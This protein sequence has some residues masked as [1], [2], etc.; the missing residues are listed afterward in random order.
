MVHGGNHMPV[1]GVHVEGLLWNL[2]KMLV[3]WWS[4]ELLLVLSD[5]LNLLGQSLDNT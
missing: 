5:L 4:I 1:L 3:S 2:A